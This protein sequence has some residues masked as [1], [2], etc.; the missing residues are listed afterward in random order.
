M[1]LRGSGLLSK[2]NH[3]HFRKATFQW[4]DE[5][6]VRFDAIY[7][8]E[9]CR[10]CRKVV[11]IHRH[12]ICGA[13]DH[14]GF[15]CRS[16]LGPHSL[17]SNAVT[18]QHFALSLRRAATVAAHRWYDERQC[19]QGAEPVDNPR[20]HLHSAGKS[21]A[22]GADGN[23][24]PGTNHASE[25]AHDFRGRFQ[26][27]VDNRFG[28]R[29]SEPDPMK[30]RNAQRRIEGQTHAAQHGDKVRSGRSKRSSCSG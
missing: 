30:R 8:K 13:G 16:N 9:K 23:R 20:Q 19:V 3:G 14:F 22:T 17:L 18:S 7:G 21:A 26:P 24:V 28:R 29:G 1:D 6:G 10:L 15:H 2:T 12:A 25:P 5:T 4:A 27:H 11:E